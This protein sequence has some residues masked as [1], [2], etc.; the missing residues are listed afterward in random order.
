MI[1]WCTRLIWTV[2]I[3]LPV[4]TFLL[5]K[6]YFDTNPEHRL[7]LKVFLAS[8][9][10]KLSIKLAYQFPWLVP[11]LRMGRAK[12]TTLCNT[13]YNVSFQT[14]EHPTFSLSIYTA[15]ECDAASPIIMYVHGGAMLF[16]TCVYDY[17]LRE[18]ASQGCFVIVAVDYRQV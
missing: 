6:P 3:L 8:Q 14:I 17:F 12:N 15:N 16:Q 9:F 2:L 13:S 4:A 18:L 1:A 10:F 11:I 5:V 7:G